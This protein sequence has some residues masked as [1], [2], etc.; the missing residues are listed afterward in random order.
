M[1][2]SNEWVNENEILDKEQIALIKA[3]ERQNK[4]NEIVCAYASI[5]ELKNSVSMNDMID[6]GYT[7]DTIVHYFRNLQRLNLQARAKYPNSFFDVD[8][9]DL[10]TPERIQKLHD[11]VSYFNRFIVTTAVTGCKI[12]ANNLVA[13]KNYCKLKNAHILVLVASDPVHNKFSPGSK[14]GTIDNSLVDDP[15]VSIVFDDVALNSNIQISTI[16]LAAKQIDQ[17][18]GMLRIAANK[19]SFIFASPKQRMK[20]VPITMGKIPYCVMTPG[21]ITEPDYTTNNYMSQRTAWIAGEDHMLGGLIVEI[22]DD[23]TYYFRQFQNDEY[24]SFIDLGIQYNS[25]DTIEAVVPT[26][27]MGDWHSGSTDPIAIQCKMEMIKLLGIKKAIMH[28]GFDSMPCNGHEEQDTILKT[29]RFRD[30][31][32]SLEKALKLFANE[33]NNLLA[34][35]DELI[36][37]KSN[38]DDMLDRWLRKGHYTQEPQNHRLALDLAA[39]LID[40]ND[41]L[42][43]GVERFGLKD[44][45]RVR[46]LE[47]DENY[48]IAGIQLGAHGHQGPNGSRGNVKNLEICYGQCVIGHAHTPEILRGAWQV[49]TSSL[50]RLTYNKG[51]SSWMHTDCLVYPNGARQLINIINGNW[52]M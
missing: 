35:I 47:L 18:T 3:A 17:T 6:A 48:K 12:N 2:D 50:L 30:G 27:V 10:R 32:L 8:V 25:D 51:P 1:I 24:G 33:I 5:A 23:N 20:A 28:D 21:A 26:L 43:Y 14:Y 11:V 9:E 44:T 13:M 36:I 37:V 15:D 19:G 29:Q 49:G 42:R 40:G 16:K 52:K 46:W 38:H 31:Q 39:Q 4:I 34:E 7:K 45:S 41:P 22:E